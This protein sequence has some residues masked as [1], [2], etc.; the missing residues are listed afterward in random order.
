MRQKL[1]ETGSQQFNLKFLKSFTIHQ[2]EQNKGF[3][4]NM[5]T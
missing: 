1:Y 2:C 4:R 5:G 3:E